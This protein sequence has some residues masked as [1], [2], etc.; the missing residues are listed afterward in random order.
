MLR[1]SKVEKFGIKGNP[2]THRPPKPFS[3]KLIEKKMT[4]KFF[5]VNYPYYALIKAKDEDEALDMYVA[6]VA[7]DDGT[8]REEIKEVDRDY[9]LIMYGRYSTEDMSIS[10]LVDDIQDDLPM[11]LLIGGTSV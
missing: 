7:D 10:T 5:E 8:L 2:K 1:P 11:V 6:F 9:A 4:M 3:Q